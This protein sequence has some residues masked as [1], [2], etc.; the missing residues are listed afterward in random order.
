MLEGRQ[1]I[2]TTLS[3]KENLRTECP[4][5]ARTVLVGSYAFNSH[6]NLARTKSHKSSDEKTQ[7]V[8]IMC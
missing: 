2:K 6:I 1:R 3:F 7:K 5:C 8:C 4:L